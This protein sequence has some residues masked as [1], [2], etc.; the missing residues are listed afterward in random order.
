MASSLISASS[1][2][3]ETGTWAALEAIFLNVGGGSWGFLPTP[4]GSLNV[5]V[6]LGFPLG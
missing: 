2:C 4:D 5:S 3:F 6:V 1:N